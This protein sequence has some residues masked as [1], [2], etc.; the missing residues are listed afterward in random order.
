M[1][2]LN[3]P[4]EMALRT[5]VLL[6]TLGDPVDLDQLIAFDFLAIHSGDVEEGPASLHPPSPHRD[7]ELLVRRQLVLDGLQV[8]VARALVEREFG[9]EGITYRTTPGGLFL[10]DHFESP[11]AKEL[12][13]RAEWIANRFGALSN[14]QVR[15]LISVETDSRLELVEENAGWLDDEYQSYGLD[16]P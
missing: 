6:T 1:T 8:L 15:A 11:Y 3:G 2:P 14:S 13:A 7:S 16:R 4:V 5:L 10:A 12:G 9:E